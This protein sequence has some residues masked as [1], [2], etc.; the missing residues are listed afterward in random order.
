ML[1]AFQICEILEL[2]TLK[3]HFG[4]KIT[5]YFN[6]QSNKDIRIEGK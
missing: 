6:G 1:C 2:G 4:N 5:N 3:T